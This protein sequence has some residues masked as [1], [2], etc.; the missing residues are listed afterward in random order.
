MDLR[1]CMSHS[2]TAYP[3][4]FSVHRDWFVSIALTR[5]SMPMPVHASHSGSC[6]MCPVGEASIVRSSI[7]ELRPSMSDSASIAVMDRHRPL[8]VRARSDTLFASA[9]TITLAKSCQGR[10]HCLSLAKSQL[11][12]KSPVIREGPSPCAPSPGRVP[13][14]SCSTPGHRRGGRSPRH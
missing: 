13:R 3:E 4:S 9:W 5:V 11:R 12:F 7:D 10:V 2:L 6:H 1:A 14:A 8:M